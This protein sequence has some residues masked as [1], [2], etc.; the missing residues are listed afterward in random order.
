MYIQVPDETSNGPPHESVPQAQGSCRTDGG[1][2]GPGTPVDSRKSNPLQDWGSGYEEVQP[3]RE[4]PFFSTQT[5]RG[6]DIQRQ[7]PQMA[8]PTPS[9]MHAQVTAHPMQMG[10]PLASPAVGGQQQ[11]ITAPSTQ[12]T[13]QMT[14][15]G[16]EQQLSISPMLDQTL[17]GFSQW[18]EDPVPA[19]SSQFLGTT[20]PQSFPQT[21][22]SSCQTMPSLPG[23]LV[24]GSLTRPAQPV[25][26][27]GQ[28]TNIMMMPSPPVQPSQI[29]ALGNITF[30]P[31]TIGASQGTPN[32]RLPTSQPI[33]AACQVN[34]A[35]GQRNLQVGQSTSNLPL[36]TSVQY[37]PAVSFGTGTVGHGIFQAGQVFSNSVLKPSQTVP[38]ISQGNNRLTQS[39]NQAGQTMFNLPLNLQTSPAT[40][41]GKGIA[42]QGVAQGGQ[43][44]TIS[45]LTIPTPST[46]SPPAVS[47]GYGPVNQAT[48][49]GQPIFGQTTAVQFP[50]PSLA[51]TL[52]QGTSGA[53]PGTPTSTMQPTPTT[54][55]IGTPGIE[56]GRGEVNSERGST[57]VQVADQTED[58]FEDGRHVNVSEETVGKQSDQAENQFE[59]I[60]VPDEAAGSESSG[61]VVEDI[62]PQLFGKTETDY[63]SEAGLRYQKKRKTEAEAGGEG[64]RKRKIARPE[65][66]KNEEREES[67]VQISLVAIN[68]LVEAIQAGNRQLAKNE[69]VMEKTERALTEVT[70]MM[71]KVVDALTQFKNVVQESANEDRKREE[72][73]FDIE[74]KREEE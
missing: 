39:A 35:V 30:Y 13:N 1:D 42:S 56:E 48:I 71:G 4:H 57:E 18:L 52:G 41:H 46:Q 14:M 43:G 16:G 31:G 27:A 25:G 62:R 5:G 63:V 67:T 19:F 69:K 66:N 26:T 45:T 9:S 32:F 61:E 51:V 15:C 64:E 59:D 8:V 23:P 3:G 38:V 53:V 74:R 65:V 33:P 70:C 47:L 40:Y 58:P 17:M 34:G 73:W 44:A 36:N 21:F 22:G 60:N 24:G 20:Q 49:Q 50:Q 12:A 37:A 28:G 68:G 55:R 6:V 29:G 10:N 72:R 54:S 2:K 7:S 11:I